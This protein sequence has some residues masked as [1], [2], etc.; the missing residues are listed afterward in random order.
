MLPGE[1]RQHAGRASIPSAASLASSVGLR[2]GPPEQHVTCESGPGS[3]RLK[4]ALAFVAI[5]PPVLEG[6]SARLIAAAATEYRG[7]LGQT[8]G[9]E[10]FQLILCGSQHG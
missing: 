8:L 10:V 6:D 4:G 5:S 9:Q 2:S 1:N 7:E 3:C